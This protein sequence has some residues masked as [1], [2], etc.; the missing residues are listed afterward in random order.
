MNNWFGQSDGYK[1]K[2]GKN[3]H[4]PVVYVVGADKDGPVKIGRTSDILSRMDQLQIGCWMKLRVFDIR[5][6]LPKDMPVMRFNIR[7]QANRGSIALER[8]AHEKLAEFD[9]RLVGEWFDVGAMD[10]LAVMEKVADG[11]NVRCINSEQLAGAKTD[12]GLD[13]EV[14][15]VHRSLLGEVISIKMAAAGWRSTPVDLE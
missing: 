7:E 6:A 14:A 11:A 2:P 5:L 15:R 13:P 9:L 1:P 4:I 12:R 3:D 8:A 10:A